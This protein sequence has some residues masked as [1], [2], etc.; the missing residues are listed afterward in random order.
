MHRLSPGGARTLR[1]DERPRADVHEAGAV[2]FRLGEAARECAEVDG[3]DGA[4]GE[5][6][7]AAGAG[8]GVGAGVRS[9]RGEICVRRLAAF[10]ETAA[11]QLRQGRRG[12][13]AGPCA[14]GSEVAE[15]ELAAA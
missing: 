11:P 1:E 10:V 14:P 6:H 4:A 15:H 13:R 8:V 5:D 3:E 7:E 2:A 9:G 12:A